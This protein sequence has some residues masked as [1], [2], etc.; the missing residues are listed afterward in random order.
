MRTSIF[1]ASLR[2]S[3]CLALAV[4][5]TTEASAQASVQGDAAQDAASEAAPM[6]IVVTA[7]KR[8]E[9]LNDVGLSISAFSA[10]T[11]ATKRINSVADLASIV[12]GLTY[13][14]S[15]TSTPVYTLRGIGFFEASL[16]AYPNV[17]TYIDQA[18]LPF[19]AMTTLTAFDLERVEVL[20]GP[21]GTLFGSNA[22]GGAINFVAAKPT[23]ELAAGVTL[24]YGRFDRAEA[25]GF[26]SGSLTDQL[27]ARL[28]VRF[29]RSD[30]W[31]L[32]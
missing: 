27:R 22:T 17:A 1:R 8:E 16:A 25:S 21:Q 23:Q 31:Q 7:N 19:P 28:A 29:E 6:D 30:G 2:A 26:I 18:P 11:L 5:V 4:S 15:T 13:T 24:G 20:K 3:A 9:S 32:S 12:P 14:P 10:E